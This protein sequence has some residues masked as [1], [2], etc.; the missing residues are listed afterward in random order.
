MKNTDKRKEIMQATLE[1]IAE[2]GFHGA[3][4][5]MIADTAGVGTGTIY[6]HFKSK[7]ALI[8]ELYLELREGIVAA[9][10]EGYSVDKPIRE[11][12]LHLST[13]LLKYFIEHSLHFRFIEQYINSPYGVTLRREKFMRE[14]SAESDV[15]KVLFE[16]G[17]TQQVM[18]DLP[19]PVH[20]ALAIGPLIAL[21]RDHALG[22]VTLDDAMIIKFAE[23]CWDGI[24]R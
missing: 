22:F 20:F 19:L 17:I 24:T 15:F 14:S 23:S 2:H 6:C 21:V 10:L 7:D 8:K 12:F 3:P 9:L 16:Q 11:R 13:M 4:M 18:K 5:A 1:L